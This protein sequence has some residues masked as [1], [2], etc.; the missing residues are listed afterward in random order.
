VSQGVLTALRGTFGPDVHTAG[1]C[2]S[3]TRT[4]DTRV[5]TVHRMRTCGA[6]VCTARRCKRVLSVTDCLAPA[7]FVSALLGPTGLQQSPFC[8]PCAPAVRTQAEWS[9]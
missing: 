3:G 6:H 1:T 7:D 5:G 2:T 9:R 4:S 8:G